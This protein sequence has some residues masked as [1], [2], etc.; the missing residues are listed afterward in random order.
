[1]IS[2][3]PFWFNR[4]RVGEAVVFNHPVYGQMIK[5]I[6]RIL[7]GGRAVFVVGLDEFSVDSRQFG[8]VARADL[9]GKVIW[10]IRQ[11]AK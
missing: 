1:M 8:P 3:I 11:T 10:H 4:L 6:E 2:K 5:Q 9:L 7:D